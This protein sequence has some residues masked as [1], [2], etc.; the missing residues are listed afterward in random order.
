VSRKD[1]G[2]ILPLGRAKQDVFWWGYDGTFTTS[3]YYADTLPTWVRR[4]NEA[5]PAQRFAGREWTPLLPASSYAE[6]D[7]VP[8]ENGGRGFTFPHRLSATR[9]RRGAPS[10]SSRGW[11]S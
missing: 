3:T 5:R 10:P 6:P 11:T 8:V 1:R 2:A 4:Y 7:S 9:T